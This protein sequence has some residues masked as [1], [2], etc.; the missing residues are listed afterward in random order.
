MEPCGFHKLL[1]QDSEFLPNVF[2]FLD[3]KQTSDEQ[4]FN[5]TCSVEFLEICCTYL[6]N[7]LI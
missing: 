2:C 6:E 5:N 1:H 7:V 3:K 4:F